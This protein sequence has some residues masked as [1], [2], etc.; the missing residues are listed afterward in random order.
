M[1]YSKTTGFYLAMAVIL[2]AVLTVGCASTKTHPPRYQAWNV[3]ITKSTTAS[4]EVDL[5]GVRDSE[6]PIWDGYNLDKYW[7]DGDLRRKDAKPLTQILKVGQPW[8]VSMNDSKWQEWLNRGATDLLVVANLPGHFDAGPADPR[9]CYLS[10][11]KYAWPPKTNT[12][13]IVIQDTMISVQTPQAL[14]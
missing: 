2:T 13:E 4:I 6:K 3:S 10:L 14:K 12:L 9:H 5:I 11:N 1:N 7:S 8:V